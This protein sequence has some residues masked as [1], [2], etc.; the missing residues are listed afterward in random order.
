MKWFATM[1]ASFLLIGIINISQI[2]L[3]GYEGRNL[4]FQ[5]HPDSSHSIRDPGEV[6]PPDLVPNGF[7]LPVGLEMGDDHIVRHVRRQVVDADLHR[8]VLHKDWDCVTFAT[9]SYLV[10]E[11]VMVS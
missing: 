8:V 10:L 4:L 5:D 9:T 1:A 2:L 7:D 6:F 3:H 11:V